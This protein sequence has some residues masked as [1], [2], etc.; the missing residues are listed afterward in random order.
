MVQEVVRL[1]FER[2][3]AH[4]DDR[5]GE[6]GVFVAI[7]EFA[8]AHVARRMDLRVVG[9]PIVD[10]D[11]LDLHAVEVELAGGPGILVAAAGTAVVERRD[12]E[13]VFALLLDDTPRDL[14][15][16]P[17]RVVP[18]GRVHAAIAIDHRVGQTL[19]LGARHFGVRELALARAADRA[20]TGIHLALVIGHE[21]EVH[22]A[23]I[24]LDDVV[25]RRREPRLCFRGLLLGQ[26]FAER[27]SDQASGRPACSRPR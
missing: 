18:R 21:H 26:V 10:A 6:L 17:K 8:H 27:S 20:E 15:D 3:G 9:R 4:G 19:R 22:V 1:R 14:G 7:V 2:V 23:A 16:E 12:D 13:A 24:L 5:V 25:H 11:V